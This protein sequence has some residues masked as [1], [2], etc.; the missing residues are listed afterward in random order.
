MM[1]AYS[2]ADKLYIYKAG[3]DRRISVANMLRTMH[4]LLLLLVVVLVA[5]SEGPS[6]PVNAEIDPALNGANDLEADASYWGYSRPWRY[7][8]GGYRGGGWGGWGGYRSGWGGGWG[9][10]GRGWW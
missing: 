6:E 3:P 9:W 2:E 1:F 10:R 8:W 7:G 5:A 4:L